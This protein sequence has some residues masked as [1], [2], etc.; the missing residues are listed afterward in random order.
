MPGIFRFPGVLPRGRVL[1]EPTSLMDVFPTVVRLGGGVLPE[2]RVIDGRD[3]LPLLRGETPHSA[4]DF[5]FHYCG[6]TLHAARWAQRER[7]K[8]WKAHFV[9]PVEDP[10][11]SGSCMGSPGSQDA[12][13]CGCA[14]AGV[15][16]H[17]PPLLF[18]LTSDPGEARPLTPHKE[19][20]FDTVLQALRQGVACH[21]KTL[22]PRPSEVGEAL[23]LWRPWLQPCCGNTCSC[24]LEGGAGDSGN[25]GGEDLEPRGWDFL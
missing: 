3:L 1:T 20:A 7:G 2:D 4:H 18:E 19:P 16:A 9:T 13:V 14:G 12:R 11:G 15:T 24:D 22:V 21:R 23:N 10:P 17:D 8:L 6:D 5:L 25:H